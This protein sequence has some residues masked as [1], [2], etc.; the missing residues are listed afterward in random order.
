MQK[1]ARCTSRAAEVKPEKGKRPQ[2]Q[3]RGGFRE[4]LGDPESYCR[5]LKNCQ[6]YGHVFV[7][8]L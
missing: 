1:L 7:I 6:N 4:K 2:S 5:G 8:E 3:Q